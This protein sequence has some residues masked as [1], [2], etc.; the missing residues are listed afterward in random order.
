METNKKSMFNLKLK[1]IRERK[2]LDPARLTGATAPSTAF[3]IMGHGAELPERKVVPPGCILVV[4]IHSGELSYLPANFFTDLFNIDEI[5]KKAFLDPVTNYKS[6]VNIIKSL[7]QNNTPLAIYREGDE[8]PDLYC[9]LLTSWDSKDQEEF[10]GQSD[11]YRLKDSGVVK[12]PFN[13]GSVIENLQHATNIIVKYT[14]PKKEQFLNLY[15]KSDYPTSDQ[16][17][18]I[19]DSNKQLKTIDEIIKFPSIANIIQKNQSEL[20][21]IL[22]PGVYYNLICRATYPSLRIIN[23]NT[24]MEILNNNKRSLVNSSGHII[25]NK[26]EILQ[27][28]EEAMFH[29]ANLIRKLNKNNSELNPLQFRNDTPVGQQELF[30]AINKN[31]LNLVIAL[32]NS[33]K[34]PVNIVSP[35]G[36]TPLVLASYYGYVDIVHELLDKGADVNVARTTDGMMPLMWASW[37]GHLKIVRELLHKGA[38][39]NAAQT[40]N[41]MTSLMWASWYGHL[42]IVREL[43][44]GGA[45]V[46]AARTSDGITSLMYASQ[47]GHLETVRELLRAGANVNA[48]QTDNGMTSLILAS[49]SGYLEIVRELLNKGA[50]VNAARSDNGSTSL[51]YSSEKGH[52]EIVRELLN[53]GANVDAA[54]TDDGITS[55]MWASQFGHLEIV[56]VLC[57]N[58]A[59][60]NIV[61]KGGLRA[62][63]YA[64]IPT[65]KFEIQNILL[66][67][68]PP[69]LT[70]T[71][72]GYCKRRKTKRNYCNKRFKR[73]A[74]K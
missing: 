71:K 3:I 46:N 29:R 67:G 63:N 60:P 70:T 19:I 45:N 48:A 10:V 11:S 47:E 42:E 38:N 62:I 74:R 4:Q 2:Q 35:D 55:L 39:V 21:E 53:K 65:N 59:D 20:F 22:G 57:Q 7:N 15:N 6:I 18:K 1:K 52:L 40:D 64:N 12:Y 16:L 41:G 32:L 24:K 54:T 43:L 72:G 68:C 56:R 49:A 30:K 14:E 28:I 23:P 8:Y 33:G 73:T 27:G 58:G 34:Y 26:R 69:M 37:Y 31:N 44:R 25:K 36:L 5:K 50:N 13:K 51:T 17:A 61:D 66:K 9:S